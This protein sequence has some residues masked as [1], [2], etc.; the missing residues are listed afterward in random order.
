MLHQK[1]HIFRELPYVYIAPF[2]TEKRNL[3]MMNV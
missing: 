1:K 2:A 3:I